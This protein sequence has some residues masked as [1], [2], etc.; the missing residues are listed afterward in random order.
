MKNF[1]KLIVILFFCTTPLMLFA[2]NK[3]PNESAASTA[4]SLVDKGCTDAAYNLGVY[5]FYGTGVTQDYN[6]SFKYFKLAADAGHT[7]AQFN[8]GE[9]YYL[10]LG[11]TK[12]P[13]ESA[14]LTK[15]LADKNDVDGL[16]HLAMLYKKGIA[17]YPKDIDKA[18]EYLTL[19]SDQ[20]YSVANY[21]LGKLYE[22]G[23]DV[24]Q[25]YP[26]AAKFYRLASDKNHSKAQ[27]K[28]AQLYLKG[29][30]VKEDKKESEKLFKLSK[31]NKQKGPAKFIRGISLT[32]DNC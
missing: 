12:N 2:D 30:G 6:Q 29:L 26:E 16:V 17:G 9:L 31:L 7:D 20:H 8:L 11:T 13:K 1:H 14:K 28:L 21:N 32:A 5:Y 4:Q 25:D 19:A 18:M 27:K 15:I 22:E 3:T 10:G 24:K 23:S